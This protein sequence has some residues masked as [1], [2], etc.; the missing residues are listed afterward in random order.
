MQGDDDDPRMLRMPKRHGVVEVAVGRQDDG[1]I[2]LR[3][4][5]DGL[6]VISKI[7]DISK[8]NGR[9]PSFGDRRGGRDR[10]VFVQQDVYAWTGA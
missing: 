5:K 10:E 2:L 8:R 6:V 7:A 1:V 3:C 9:M 4:R